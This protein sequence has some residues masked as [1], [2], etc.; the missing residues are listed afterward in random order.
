M[1]DITA[2]NKQI[3]KLENKVSTNLQNSNYKKAA[4]LMTIACSILY[5]SN[6]CYKCDWIE[7]GINV[8]ASELNNIDGFRS[9]NDDYFLFYDSFGLDNRGIALIYLQA[10]SKHKKIIYITKNTN[11]LQSV[12]IKKTISQSGGESYALD[13][14][15]PLEA[16]DTLV[17]IY[18]KY[19]MKVCFSYLSPKDI[20]AAVFFTLLSEADTYRFF[21]DITDHA[22]WCGINS[23]DKIIEFRDY[24]CYIDNVFRSIDKEMILLLPYYPEINKE[25]EFG[26]F[27]FT[28]NPNQIV[29]FSGGAIYKTISTDK[30]Y[31]KAI[32]EILDRHS[33]VIFWYAGDNKCPDFVHLETKHKGK[34][35]FTHE[36]K[37]LYEILKHSFMYINTYPIIG[38]LM[39]QYAACAGKI[40]FTLKYDDCIDG[41]LI[42]QNELGIVAETYDDYISKLERAINSEKY[43]MELE[44]KMPSAV[45]SKSLFEQQIENLILYKKTDFDPQYKKID[46]T[47]FRRSYLDRFSVDKMNMLFPHS[48][49][50]STITDFPIEWILGFIK[51]IEKR[52]MKE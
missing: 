37:D 26:G 45:P 2:I 20:P 47:E 6:A 21:I 48:R 49:F 24:G 13:T 43:R 50:Y 10:L 38:G 40:P 14:N 5:Q 25:I 31:Y 36:R 44:N 9:N 41:F 17:K 32:D 22:F 15:D 27:P 23:F 19:K 7:N 11:T 29:L 39:T 8:L 18:L 42:N 28:V 34:V 52:I 35:W 3:E 30:L 16:I 46:T 1:I 12:R 51:I 4:E 33:E